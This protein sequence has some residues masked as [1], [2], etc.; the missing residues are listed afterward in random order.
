MEG[1]ASWTN[2]GTVRY[3]DDDGKD[4]DPIPSNEVV[5]KADGQPG[6]DNP[7]DPAK[8]DEPNTPDEPSDWPFDHEKVDIVDPGDPTPLP[9]PEGPSGS[10]MAP[11]GDTLPLTAVAVVPVV[12]VGAAAVALFALRRLA[13]RK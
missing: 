7:D 12:L 3:V 11:T 9:A 2:I 10:A 1:S 4:V 5:V 13:A 6:P 8:P